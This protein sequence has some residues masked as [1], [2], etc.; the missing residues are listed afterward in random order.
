VLLPLLDPKE[1]G[2]I[3]T[4]RTRIEG[5]QAHIIPAL[6]SIFDQI[7]AGIL[8]QVGLTEVEYATR[9]WS[10]IIETIVTLTEL[11]D[12]LVQGVV[13]LTIVQL[14]TS[15][16]HRASSSNVAVNRQFER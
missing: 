9:V 5:I 15:N 8:S 12:A 16:Q 10:R 14:R 7:A 2:N 11:I 3:W 1:V 13:Q 4:R 6:I